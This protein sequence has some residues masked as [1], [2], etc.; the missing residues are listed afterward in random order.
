M[1]IKCTK[2][3]YRK[4]QS[5]AVTCTDRGGRGADDIT[6]TAAITQSPERKHDSERGH[7][8]GS[9]GNAGLSRRSEAGLNLGLNILVNPDSIY[10]LDYK[11]LI[12]CYVK[13]L[14]SQ[15]IYLHSWRNISMICNL[16]RL[17]ATE[18]WLHPDAVMS[19]CSGL[20]DQRSGWAEEWRHPPVLDTIR[21]WRLNYLDWAC[22]SLPSGTNMHNR[23]PSRCSGK[24]WCRRQTLIQRW[25]A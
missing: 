4:H 8:T 25:C 5:R 20:T 11:L 16:N 23:S 3:D 14:L 1:Y 22:C 10:F 15:W 24:R 12:F 17:H 9:W 2:G 19:A 21:K 13:S 18:H 7:V 6:T